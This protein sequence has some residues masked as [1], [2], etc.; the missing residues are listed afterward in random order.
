MLILI[1]A[2]LG[3]V[4]T[5]LSPCVLPVIPFVFARSDRPFVKSGFPMLAG[6]ALS[7]S[8]FAALSVTGGNWIIQ[9]NQYGRMIALIIFSIVGLS[10]LFPTI[11][12]RL[13]RPFVRL[14]AALQKKSHG[15]TGI[16]SSLLLGMSI[17][18]LWAPCAGPILGLVLAGAAVGGSTQKTLGLLLVFAAGA[19]TS[20]GVAIFAGG[21]VM[22]QLK[23]GFGAE[24]WIRKF[25][26]FA[27]LCA[28]VAI[29]FGWDTRL[30]A[31]FSYINTGSLE[32]KL[33][34]RVSSSA[35]IQ[36]KSVQLS[37]EGAMPSIAGATD[38]INS[39]PLTNESLKGKVVLIDFWTYSCINCLRALPYVKAW[40]DTYKDQGLVVIGVH[41]P[42]F[43]F[44]R[45]TGNVKKAVKDLGITYP[46]AVDSRNA[47]WDAFQNQYWPAH[48]FIDAKGRIRA[49]H[50]GEGE[51]EGSEKIIQTLLGEIRTDKNGIVENEMTKPEHAI[52]VQA[53]SSQ[54]NT[55]PE[56]YI[57][58]DR[59]Q[60]FSSLPPIQNDKAVTYT[61]SSSLSLNHWS[62]V[63]VW[64]ISAEM[65]TLVSP[66]GKLSY[67]FS[68]R[69]LHLVLGTSNHKPVRF[70]VLIDGKEPAMDHGGDIDA[71]GHGVVTSH[72]LYQLIRQ[73][74]ASTDRT[75]SIEFLDPAVQV[76]AF[77]FG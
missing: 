71:N 18:L 22:R 30:L 41:T 69:D 50:F 70:R 14:G 63:G 72:R 48:Y 68:G 53:P 33:I 45:V 28:V 66:S 9:A 36:A 55:S 27:V 25:L 51:Y 16:G 61:A 40:A 56:T 49:H 77:T 67:R 44:E 57:G 76:F 42:E 11:A 35:L 37:D 64:N 15:K 43:A 74:Q 23:K 58:Y 31:K 12:E 13:T 3:G 2:Y 21:K 39:P 7:F 54:L 8:F 46:V 26:G 59:Q 65:A 75:F 5:I 4:L 60:G 10:L 73:R 1:L 47:I 62:L 34:N 38:W 17:G 20:L 19:A 6:M 32:Q 52:G 29:M 24:E